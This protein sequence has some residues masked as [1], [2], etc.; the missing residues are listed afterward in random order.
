MKEAVEEG[1]AVEEKRGRRY[2]EGDRMVEQGGNFCRVFWGREF[3][4][5]K[6]VKKVLEEKGRKLEEGVNS[7]GKN[8]THQT[9]KL[10]SGLSVRGLGG[11]ET[12]RF[13]RATRFN[14]GRQ[15]GSSK[16]ASRLRRGRGKATG[17]RIHG[18]S[19]ACLKFRYFSV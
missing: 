19:S 1:K 17:V 16:L 15:G 9:G 11:Q 12:R 8:Y 13:P 10:L 18:L 14:A 3:F 7:R 4:Q 6:G 2:K 5:K